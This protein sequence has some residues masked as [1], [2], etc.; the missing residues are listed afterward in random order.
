MNV[1]LALHEIVSLISPL[2]PGG[3]A[4]LLWALASPHHSSILWNHPEIGYRTRLT[5]LTLAAWI[6]G[7]SMHLLA[8]FCKRA[9]SKFFLPRFD[10]QVDQLVKT[11]QTLPWNETTWRKS[12]EVFLD[13]VAPES[14]DQNAWQSWYRYFYDLSSSLQPPEVLLD[15]SIGYNLSYCGMIGFIAFFSS[16]IY[17]Q[18]WILVASIPQVI[19]FYFLIKFGYYGPAILNVNTMIQKE[20]FIRKSR[21]EASEKASKD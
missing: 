19:I 10:P 1:K 20:F 6:L 13:R 4:I 15:R 2:L 18:W 12:A 8:F 11:N 14:W 3:L 9:V 7:R 17:R 5:I 16:P 21:L